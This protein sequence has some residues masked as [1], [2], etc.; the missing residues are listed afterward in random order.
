MPAASAISTRCDRLCACIS[1]ITGPVDFHGA[2]A[3]PE[4]KGDFLAE[5]A[6][7]QLL[8]DF[9][10]APG[11]PRQST[12]GLLGLRRSGAAGGERVANAAHE[13]RGR[14]TGSR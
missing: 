10:L 5:A 2:W 6:D 8:Q 1:S 7:H 3:G 11:E 14:E 13:R 12:V 9:A 4:L